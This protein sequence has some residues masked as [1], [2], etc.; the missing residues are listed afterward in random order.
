M[1]DGVASAAYAPSPKLGST[2]RR[3]QRNGPAVVAD[4]QPSVTEQRHP[5]ERLQRDRQKADAVGSEFPIDVGPSRRS[6]PRRGHQNK[7][8]QDGGKQMPSD[9]KAKAHPVIETEKARRVAAEPMPEQGWVRSL[10]LKPQPSAVSGTK[11]R[12]WHSRRTCH[13]RRTFAP[14]AR[15]VGRLIESLKDHAERDPAD[16]QGC[17]G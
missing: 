11:S 7:R 5:P 2:C 15:R 14:A 9:A 6:A 4:E 12:R 10:K 3:K 8:R 1:D 17:E 13:P 16:E